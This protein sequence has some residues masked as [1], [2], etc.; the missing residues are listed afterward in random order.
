MLSLHNLAYY[1]GLMKRVR[2]AI[3]AGNLKQLAADEAKRCPPL[4]TRRP[5]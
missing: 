3:A 4:A 5:V 1:L 2:G